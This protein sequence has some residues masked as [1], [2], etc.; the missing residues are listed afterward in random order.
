MCVFSLIYSY[1]AVRTFCAVCCLIIMCFY[2]LFFNYAPYVFNILFMFVFLFCVFVFYI[3][4]SVPF[5]F[6]LLLFLLSYIAVS[7]LFFMQ[8]YRPLPPCGNPNAV[9]KYLTSYIWSLKHVTSSFRNGLYGGFMQCNTTV[10]WIYF[11]QGTCNTFHSVTPTV[12][13]LSEI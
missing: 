4:Y 11:I 8:V 3:V 10:Y 1:A 2:L 7:F 6:F 12:D 13:M 5:Y 9:N